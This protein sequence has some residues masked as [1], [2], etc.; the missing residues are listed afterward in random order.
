MTARGI[1]QWKRF[2]NLYKATFVIYE[3]T[4]ARLTVS[5][6]FK[7]RKKRER[8]KKEKITSGKMKLTICVDSTD[9]AGYTMH[10]DRSSSSFIKP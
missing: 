8:K 6:I 3:W 9:I 5:I 7:F 4:F 10:A 2:G 1:V